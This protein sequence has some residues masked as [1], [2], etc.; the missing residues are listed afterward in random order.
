MNF[1]KMNALA[2]LVSATVNRT[3]IGVALLASVPGISTLAHAQDE[4]VQAVPLTVGTPVTFTFTSTFPTAS[5]SIPVNTQCADGTLLWTETTPDLWYSFVAPSNG[6]LTLDTCEADPFNSADTSLV[7]Y[8]GDCGS[9]VQVACNGDFFGFNPAGT[10]SHTTA[11]INSYL[12]I[13]GTTYWVRVGSIDGSLGTILPGHITATMSK[14]GGWG[15]TGSGQISAPSALGLPSKISAGTQHVLGLSGGVVFAWGNNGSGRAT[16]PAGLGTVID[17]SAGGSH[18][19]ALRS[20][21]TVA[22]WG[23]DTSLRATGGS[24]VTNAVAIA[25]GGSHS[26][27]ALATGTVFG[28]G[29]N[30][31]GQI[32]IPAGLTGVVKVTAGVSHSVAL[33]SNDAVTA[34]GLNTSGQATVPGGLVATKIASSA[35]SGHTL[36]LRANGTIIGWGLNTSGQTNIPAGLTGMID[37]AAGAAHSIALFADGTVATWGSNNSGE[38]TVPSNLGPSNIVA[39]GAGYSLTVFNEDALDLCP[40]DPN[41]LRPGQCGCGVADTDTDSDGTADCND[42]CPTVAGLLAPRTFFADVDLDTFGNA[43][44][45]TAFCS[46]TAPEG[47]AANST[48][49]D[50]ASLLYADADNDTYGAGAPTACGVALNTDCNDSDAA[51]N[52]GATEICDA[53]NVDENCNAL[54][55]NADATAADSGKSNFFADSDA[56]T[57]TVA[58]ATRY[59]DIV[60]GYLAAVSAPIDCNDSVAAI[61]PGATEICDAADVDENCNNIADN[62]DI[63]ASDA[64]KSDFFADSDSDT[65]TAG[66]ATRYCDIV[67]GY[68]ATVSASID[69]NDS[70]AAINPAATEICDAANVD[71]NCNNLA[72]N[73]DSSAADAGRSDFFADS[74]SDSYTV[75]TATRFCDIA[76]GYLA[77]VSPSIDCNDAVAAINPGAA[78]ICDAADVDEDCNAL[79]DNADLGATDATKSDFFADSDSDTYT[80]A[81]ATRFCDIAVGYLA[82]VSA[83]IDCNDSVAA[84]NPGATEICDAAN[85]DENCNTLADNADIGATDATKSDFFADSDSDT[86]TVAAA[87]RYCDIVTG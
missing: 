59:C 18:S 60:T 73:A 52:P 72:D 63:G 56:D 25:A 53:A 80:V 11:R 45:T 74:D 2:H 36:A 54:A 8:T 19:L 65:Y 31:N 35:S 28:W 5:A 9:L 48:D 37:V 84:I 55:D 33:R 27:A 47:F 57:Y 12:V 6:L 39:A 20:G 79:A 30:T 76:A 17:I 66:S 16:V 4:C 81:S 71:E 1:E 42:G 68:F 13:A 44:S 83:S 43:A 61:N 46:L 21:G 51:I 75:A 40:N 70:D 15:Q 38:L 10:C 69:C 49:C 14:V 67:T 64:S 87:T 82:L 41:K 3:T 22:G 77:L 86:Y 29:V 7:L 34:W 26:L 78:E 32:T 62:A 23:L 58:A 24:T 50:D 85:V